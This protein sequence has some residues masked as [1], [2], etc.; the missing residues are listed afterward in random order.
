MNIVL[1]SALSAFFIVAGLSAT[2]SLL[3]RAGSVGGRIAATC[4]RAPVLDI[5]VS[6]FTWIPWVLAGF[7]FGWQGILGA[8]AGQILGLFAWVY[9]H[10]LAHRDATRGPRIVKFLNRVVGRGRNHAALWVTAV[11]LPGFLLIRLIEIVCY[12]WLIWLLKFPKYNQAEWVNVSR[13][14]FDGLVGHDLIWCLYCDWMTGVYALGAEML[15]NVESFWCPIRFYD[16]KKCDNCKLDFPDVAGGWVAATATMADVEKT[17]QEHYGSGNRSWFGHK[18]RI[19][20]K[21]QSV[22]PRD[23]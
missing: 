19:T 9:G 15:R 18:T 14:K 17:M 1:T 6:I 3:H 2:L 13:Q 7:A 16:G 22:G 23:A 12:P 8:L 20:V 11:A 5:V 10:E 21:G 4:C